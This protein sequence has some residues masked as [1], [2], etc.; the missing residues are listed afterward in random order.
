MKRPS[1]LLRIIVISSLVLIAV[2]AVL[3][4]TLGTDKAQPLIFQ[5]Q[6]GSISLRSFES[7]GGRGSTKSSDP[8]DLLLRAEI[9]VVMSMS[10][11]EA[12]SGYVENPLGERYCRFP[13]PQ[14]LDADLFYFSIVFNDSIDPLLLS[15]GYNVTRMFEGR[16]ASPELIQ[17]VDDVGDDA[18][19]GGPGDELWQGLHILVRDVYITVKVHSGDAEIDYRVSRNMAV[20]ALERL[21][22]P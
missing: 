21:F 4:A 20:A 18:F 6:P 12:Q 8:C 9:E 14:A 1:N 15:D 10:L 2:V 7:P 3:L 19:W 16:K 17:T 5:S 22:K 11:A 13:D